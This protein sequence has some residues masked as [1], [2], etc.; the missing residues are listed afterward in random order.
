MSKS[1]H[2]QHT[3]VP[4]TNDIFI[5]HVKE[6][7]IDEVRSLLLQ[8]KK[9]ASA[10]DSKYKMPVLFWAMD[11]TPNIDM[12]RLLLDQ[13]I[14]T[15][16]KYDYNDEEDEEDEDDDYYN[17]LEIDS[18]LNKAIKAGSPEIV[19]LLLEHGADTKVND[20][21]GYY[22]ACLALE[23]PNNVA[24]VKL[25]LKHGADVKASYVGCEGVTLLMEAVKRG[26]SEV[27]KIIIE[28]GAIDT[29]DKNG[30]T[31]LQIAEQ[32]VKSGYSGA[33][34]TVKILREFNN[35]DSNNGPA[36]EEEMPPVGDVLDPEVE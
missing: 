35:S 10:V 19:E 7:N 25:L 36:A 15:N 30:N 8:D 20:L 14:S 17:D 13:G 32:G 34:E 9:L 21:N 5:N 2:A 27:I 16:Y 24:I 29:V 3:D 31:E 22:P 18:A 26:L 1:N 28:H 33:I 6:G 4:L 23:Q 12:I 11:Q